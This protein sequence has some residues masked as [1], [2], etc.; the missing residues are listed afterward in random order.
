MNINKINILCRVI[1][2]STLSFPVFHVNS[3]EQE[4]Q[5]NS[6]S[7]I[8]NERQATAEEI[9]NVINITNGFDVSLEDKVYF[10]GSYYSGGMG[11]SHYIVKAFNQLPYFTID[12]VERIDG[13]R[14][15]LYDKYYNLK[16][17]EIQSSSTCNIRNIHFAKLSSEKTSAITK[18]N[19]KTFVELWH[20]FE[21]GELARL[22]KISAI[23]LYDLISKDRITVSWDYYDIVADKYIL[24]NFSDLRDLN[25]LKPRFINLET[26]KNGLREYVIYFYDIEYKIPGVIMKIRRNIDKGSKYKI[27]INLNRFV[28]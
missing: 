25:K 2:F 13:A 6:G 15:V 23:P 26:P 1:T 11:E 9:Q 3:N 21:D 28:P 19:L 24:E 22:L 18:D 16:K 20:D 7:L 5:I 27:F 14:Y 10:D 8:Y 12:Q 4:N 17:C